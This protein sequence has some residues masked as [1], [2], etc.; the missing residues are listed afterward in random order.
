MIK[1]RV[2]L[3]FILLIVAF[4]SCVFEPD[5]TPLPDEVYV[6][7]FGASGSQSTTDMI[8]NSAGN[9]V[10]LGDQT[11][12]T[13]GATRDAW[14]IEADTIGNMIR[15]NSFGIGTDTAYMTGE[16]TESIKE[17]PQG[18]LVTG[19][20]AELT[21]GE[22]Q[23]FNI[24]W[25]WLD[26]DLQIMKTDTIRTGDY[27][28]EGAL[29][30]HVYGRDIIQ[31]NDGNIV[32]VGKTTR[33]ELND[34][35]TDPGE[36][37]FLVK[38][39]FN[40]DT[41]IWRK[42]YGYR[43]SDDD[44]IAVF[45]LEDGNLAIIGGTDQPGA[46]GGTGR[47]VGIMVFGPLATSQVTAKVYGVSI[48]GDNTTMDQPNDVIKVS[49]GF[50]IVGTSAQGL[51]QRAFLMGIFDSG[52][53]I[54]SRTLESKWGD[55]DITGT[56]VTQTQEGDLAV[57]GSYPDF[58]VLDPSV[59]PNLQNKNGEVLFMRTGQAGIEKDA[60]EGNFG[61]V[62]GNDIGQVSCTLPGGSI[63]IGATIDFGSNQTMIALMKL[64]D[65]GV[66]Q[67]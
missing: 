38:R 19:S 14:V 50:T 18:Y 54:F 17:F 61:L 4:S 46:G 67:R 10:I 29:A 43:S 6:K 12:A 45:E 65:L 47:N 56:S 41:T 48:D 7:Y 51:N 30:D 25:A 28:A 2:N 23:Q 35:T 26:F 31:T 59:N 33:R 58:E 42:S 16:F 36:Q 24:F 32:I 40:A 1:S 22:T 37:Y 27:F 55:I 11:L 5:D 66:L 62:S 53:K 34:L 9:I 21:E 52:A 49:D 60:F 13:P 63:V 20:F 57:T 8:V 15:S 44:A 3:L 64:N 39:D